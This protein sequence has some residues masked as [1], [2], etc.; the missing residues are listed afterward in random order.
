[1]EVRSEQRIK[2]AGGLRTQFHH[3]IDAQGSDP[4]ASLTN[5]NVS[6]SAFVGIQSIGLL[7]G[8]GLGSGVFNGRPTPSATPSVK[9][10]PSGVVD[11]GATG[12]GGS[13]GQGVGGGIDLAAGGSVR[14]DAFN[15]A[16]VKYNDAITSDDDVFGNLSLF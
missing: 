2:D 9:V 1:M 6:H 7:G 15:Q 4:R 12:N 10:E 16:H 8:D 13:A 14:L 5:R 3:C 11:D